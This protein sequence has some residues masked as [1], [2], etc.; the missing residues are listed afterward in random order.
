M[1]AVTLRPG[2]VAVVDIKD[3]KKWFGKDD[4]EAEG[5]V[6]LFGQ[7]LKK[8]GFGGVHYTNPALKGKLMADTIQV[9]NAGSTKIRSIVDLDTNKRIQ[10]KDLQGK[11][12]SD[13][14]G[15]KE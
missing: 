7:W 6:R 13:A 10:T 3:F 12:F 9:F 4:P 14:F 8:N 5:R 11:S 2:K 1:F 15:A